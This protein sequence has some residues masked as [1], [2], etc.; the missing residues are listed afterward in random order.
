MDD[1][2][3]PFSHITDGDYHSV[4]EEPFFAWLKELRARLGI[5]VTLYCF[6]EDKS[7]NFFMDSVTA[8]YKAEFESN[9]GWLHFAFHARN[10]ESSYS[11]SDACLLAGDYHEGMAQ[12]ER[13]VGKSSLSHTL[14]LHCWQGSKSE[15]EKMVYDADYPLAALL[16]PN[17]GKAGY[18]LDAI[19]NHRLQ[20]DFY[21]FDESV[22]CAFYKTDLRIESVAD[23]RRVPYKNLCHTH[24][25]QVSVFTHAWALA[26]QKVKADTEYVLE[27][28]GKLNGRLYV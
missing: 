5:S 17:D 23:V 19:Q 25:R 12:L 28:L 15:V 27:N 26:E 6:F 22:G 9:A 20:K 18:Y 4:F 14:R 16:T 21:L 24:Q 10:A 8:R 1:V 3:E 7:K 13:I 2:W 11:G